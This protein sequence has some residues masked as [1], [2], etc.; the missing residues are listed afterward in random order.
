MK[1]EKELVLMPHINNLNGI[2]I[3]CSHCGSE[4]EETAGGYY[5]P[6][7]YQSDRYGRECRRCLTELGFF[8]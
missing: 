7:K 1:K 3:L 8:S 4:F 5:S 6:I 2:I